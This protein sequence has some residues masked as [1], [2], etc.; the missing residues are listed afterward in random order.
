[1]GLCHVCRHVA[2]LATPLQLGG[3]VM[4][5]CQVDST[6]QENRMIKPP[7][8]FFR[9]IINILLILILIVCLVVIIKTLRCVF[10]VG[11]S[12]VFCFCKNT[13]STETRKDLKIAKI[14]LKDYQ[15]TQT[16]QENERQKHVI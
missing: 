11:T 6:Q 1:M 8:N 5:C 14:L 12:S 10:K 7:Y 16:K 9:V 3:H 13:K 2:T 15:K 4:A